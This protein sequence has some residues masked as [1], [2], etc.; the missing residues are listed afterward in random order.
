MAEDIGGV[1]RTI[2]GRRVF[3]K[4]GQDLASAM[5]ES[6]K[7]K[8]TINQTKKEKK[9]TYKEYV[10]K[11]GYDYEKENEKTLYENNVKTEA[12]RKA[13]KDYAE[14]ESKGKISNNY[15][16]INGYYNKTKQFSKVDAESLE[17]AAEQIESCIKGK[18]DKD[19]YTFRGIA[20]KSKDI[21]VG[22]EILNKGFTST[23]IDKT[24]A[25][26]FA[27]Y[28]NGVLINIKVS[29]GTEALY[30]GANSGSG[31]NEAELLFKRNAKIIIT[32]KNEEGI[33]GEIKYEK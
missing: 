32:E 2:G 11:N 24:I 8:K 4:E 1:W 33:F 23:S 25:K 7:F 26:D 28:Y 22:D 16:N 20:I 13:L 18:T 27:D 15:E 29:K 30:I 12:Q 10:Y 5:K 21:N 3:I 17:N 14:E 31:Y 6:G 9:V 19:I